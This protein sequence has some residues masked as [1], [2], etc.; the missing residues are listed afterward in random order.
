MAW[1][2]GQVYGQDLR[3][4]VLAASGSIKEVAARFAVSES[5]VARARSRR[6]R[7][8]EDTPGVQCNHMPP[9]LRG[10]EPALA[11]RVEA[12]PDQTL[13]QLCQW[14]Q[15]EHGVQVGV[16]AMWK[17]L[18]RLGLSLKKNRCVPP[19]RSGPT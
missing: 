15:A 17:T 18:A 6:K 19:S 11:A 10:L 3:D 2:S 13:A 12:V 8:G 16:T 7:H 1:H 4:R 9:K 5:Y 14:V